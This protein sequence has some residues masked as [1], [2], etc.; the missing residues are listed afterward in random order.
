[1]RRILLYG[2]RATNK[3]FDKV[4]QAQNIFRSEPATTVRNDFE[5]ILRLGVGPAD[6]HVLQPPRVITEIDAVFAPSLLI[7]HELELLTQQWVK[8][9]SY[10]NDR[11]S[12]RINCI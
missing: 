9:V 6:R 1:M 10:S 11:P 8:L 3:T 7:G 4:R 2:L 5:L 12:S